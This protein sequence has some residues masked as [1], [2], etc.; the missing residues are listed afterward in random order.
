MKRLNKSK[1][2]IGRQKIAVVATVCALGIA[3]SLAT[4]N[5]A[6]KTMPDGGTFDAEYYAQNNPDVVAALGSDENVL[7]QHYINYGKAEGRA[8]YQQAVKLTDDEIRA[9]AYAMQAMYPDGM[10]W[11]RYRCSSFAVTIQRGVF[12]NQYKQTKIVDPEQVGLPAGTKQKIT[13]HGL[14]QPLSFD[15]ITV[16]SCVE[17]IGTWTP[18]HDVFVLEKDAN[19]ITVCEG[20]F[21][22]KVKWGRKIYKN[23][24]APSSDY[25]ELT[26]VAFIVTG[27]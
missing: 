18:L 23:N 22:A 26:K 25:E 19:S 7:Y 2:K 4:S 6:P 11:G 24:C 3:A 10:Y 16:G 27:Q 20:S 17:Y 14:I 15:D 9:K 13:A 5:A 21:N 12:G 8:P 1:R